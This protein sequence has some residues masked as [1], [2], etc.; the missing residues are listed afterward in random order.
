MRVGMSTRIWMSQPGAPLSGYRP[1][2]HATAEHRPLYF[3]V[4][5]IENKTGEL[6]TA[7]LIDGL[8]IG[9]KWAE[10]IKEK[11][12]DIGF[13]YC[14][15][16]TIASTHSHSS[17]IAAFCEEDVM[18]QVFP[19]VIAASDPDEE[20]CR[21]IVES[22]QEAQESM[23][24]LV[25]IRLYNHAIPNVGASRRDQGVFPWVPLQVA[26]FIRAKK[27]PILWANYP[28][29][30][31]VLNR[32]HT[33]ISPD[34]HGTA[35][36]QLM[37]KGYLV[38]G[39]WNGPAADISTRYTRRES[40]VRE[41][42]L[43]ASRLT[44]QIVDVLDHSH[45]DSEIQPSNIVASKM[46]YSLRPKVRLEDSP[47]LSLPEDI[48]EGIGFISSVTLP[49]Y[50]LDVSTWKIGPWSI[51]WV[52]GELPLCSFLVDNRERTRFPASRWIIGY[53]NDYPGYL[54]PED[55]VSY[56][57]VMTLYDTRDIRRLIADLKGI[58]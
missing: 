32:Y 46:S 55:D 15:Y 28:C 45:W 12:Q 14:D 16:L 33:L 10:R 21:V 18:A 51:R 29:H 40:S 7:V 9:K 2:R 1:I 41:L 43:L 53:A 27:Q 44:D 56:E 30:P 11:I 47:D 17:T 24:D 58:S 22:I 39:I 49:P 36:Q 4:T 42:E 37:E 6:F 48:S 19:D 23:D 50:A 35:A 25:S 13:D 38:G 52:P 3:G 34:L 20:T 31:T 5:V 26:Q 54:M 8:A 57:S